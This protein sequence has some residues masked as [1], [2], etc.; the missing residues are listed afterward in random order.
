MAASTPPAHSAHF[1]W[2]LQAIHILV[3]RKL[4]PFTARTA[5][6]ISS[7]LV[8]SA[9][10]TYPL[11]SNTRIYKPVSNLVTSSSTGFEPCQ[12]AMSFEHGW[13]VIWEPLTY[14]LLQAISFNR[15]QYAP[16][17]FTAFSLAGSVI[18]GRLLRQRPLIPSHKAKPPE[19]A[20]LLSM[21]HQPAFIPFHSLR[22]F[23]SSF[24]QSLSQPHSSI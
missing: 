15:P 11:S 16:L 10:Y 20:Q 23:R 3:P 14:M 18:R 2:Q 4:M 24:T 5:A 1:L 22:S 12:Q 6:N 8:I 7:Y 9:A 19:S 21:L 13:Q 17:N